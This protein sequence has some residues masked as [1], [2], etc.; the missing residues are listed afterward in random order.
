MVPREPPPAG[1]GEEPRGHYL[2]DLRQDL[3][4]QLL[5]LGVLKAQP[6]LP[7]GQGLLEQQAGLGLGWGWGD[8]G[9]QEPRHAGPGL[10]ELQ[11]VPHELQEPAGHLNWLRGRRCRHR[12]SGLGRHLLLPL[13]LRQVGE[14]RPGGQPGLSVSWTGF[15]APYSLSASS[16]SVSS[17]LVPPR[18]Q[19]YT[20]QPGA[21]SAQVRAWSLRSCWVRATREGPPTPSCSGPT[22]GAGLARSE[23]QGPPSG[24]PRAAFLGLPKSQTGVERVVQTGPQPGAGKPLT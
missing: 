23:G 20:H 18:P 21:S 6:Q 4:Q 19:A 24:P 22:V 10:R 9:H 1:G 17:P 5:P 16:S 13:L 3:V 14:P 8:W 12:S 11:G 15:L 7:R 2:S